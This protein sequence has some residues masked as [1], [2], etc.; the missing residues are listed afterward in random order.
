[1]N[2]AEPRVTTRC[3]RSIRVAGMNPA[4]SS[5][6]LC[7]ACTLLIRRGS[8][9]EFR[10]MAI[11]HT[12][13]DRTQREASWTRGHT[14]CPLPSLVNTLT[15]GRRVVTLTCFR[16]SGPFGKLQLSDKCDSGR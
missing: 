11:G 5:G 7:T 4:L 8:I 12:G 16:S 1:M 13:A 14:R 3:L 6:R 9:C 2:S 10:A 15:N